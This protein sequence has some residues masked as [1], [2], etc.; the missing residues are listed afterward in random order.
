[1]STLRPLHTRFDSPQFTISI[2]HSPLS[3]SRSFAEI[4]CY[5]HCLSPFIALTYRPCTPSSFRSSP[6]TIL[7][8]ALYG[9]VKTCFAFLLSSP[10]LFRA[11]TI[12]PVL[13]LFSFLKH[14]PCLRN[15]NP[16]LPLPSPSLPILHFNTSVSNHDR[17]EASHERLPW[18][19]NR[20][21]A[22]QEQRLSSPKTP[23]FNNVDNYALYS[24]AG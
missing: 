19:A 16:T 8:L 11:T 22:W 6:S 3:F 18:R 5:I 13:V 2:P 21:H 15:N 7:K 12:L 9:I 23:P 1:M 4:G 17:H 20:Q 24:T 10:F 14:T